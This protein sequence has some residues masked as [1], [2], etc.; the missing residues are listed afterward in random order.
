MVTTLELQVRLY[1]LAFSN[2]EMNHC[3]DGKSHGRGLLFLNIMIAQFSSCHCLLIT[4]QNSEV[5][6]KKVNQRLVLNFYHK[7]LIIRKAN[8]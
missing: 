1:P 6:F 8:S 4:H 2:G 3:F 7:L 5:W